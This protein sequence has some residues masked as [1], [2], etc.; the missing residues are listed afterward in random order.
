MSKRERTKKES[1]KMIFLVLF[2]LRVCV[3]HEKEEEERK[4][5]EKK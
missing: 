4:T 2:E 5:K 1:F 3:N